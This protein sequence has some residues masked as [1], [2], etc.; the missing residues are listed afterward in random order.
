MVYKEISCAFCSRAFHRKSGQANEAIKFEWKQYCSIECQ[1]AARLTGA[2]HIC[3]TCGN[4][5]WRTPKELKQSK[6]Q[7]FFCNTSC[8]AIHNNRLRSEA[9]PKNFCKHP[10]CK[11]QIPKDQL[12][13]SRSCAIFSR[14]RTIES[15]RQE[16]LS[17]IRNF[18]KLNGRIPV[19]KEHYALYSKARDA[20]GTW[21]KAIES[22][23]Y[24]SNP[25]MFAD[26]HVARDGHKCDSIAE[27]II[28]EW[29]YSKGIPHER[30][31]PY[32]EG[33]RLT[34]DFVVNKTFIE[35]FGLKGEL[36]AYD[37]LA[38]LKIKLSKKHKLKLVQIKPKDL[39]PRNKLDQVLNFLI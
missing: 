17:G 25:V 16:V 26:K 4:N 2:I 31:V 20:F 5:V 9:L 15:L 33:N 7:R 23:G 38:N 13:C 6:T 30:S 36:K 24:K 28:D 19:K 12:Y 3:K 11:K 29:L 39:F 27:K 32:P 8:A 22:A 21:N 10:G 18:H 35:F 14:K 1:F 34:C 37:R